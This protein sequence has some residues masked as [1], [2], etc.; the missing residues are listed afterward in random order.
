MIVAVTLFTLAEGR[1]LEDYRRFSREFIGPGMLELPSVL[2][3]RDG[4][5]LRQMGGDSARWH[6]VEVIEI[7]SPEAFEADH[8]VA[9]GKDV[10][11]RWREWIDRYEV[12]FFELVHEG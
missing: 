12:T 1:S 9:P 6:G 4:T 8:E 2:G 5:A 3:F 11:A 7:S 10:A